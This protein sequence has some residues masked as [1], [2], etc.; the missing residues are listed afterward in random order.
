[1]GDNILKSK[2]MG[3]NIRDH[4]ASMLSNEWKSEST[5]RY[6][7]NLHATIV[8][9]LKVHEATSEGEAGMFDEYL[10]GD[11]GGFSRQQMLKRNLI[12]GEI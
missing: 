1:M 11:P 3:D 5:L 4:N 6:C 2:E 10:N 8:S 7:D 9:S 12:A